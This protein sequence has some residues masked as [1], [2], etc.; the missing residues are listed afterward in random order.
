MTGDGNEIGV[1]RDAHQ[2][3]PWYG[4]PSTWMGTSRVRA[5]VLGSLVVFLAVCLVVVSLTAY[6]KYRSVWDSI[7]RVQVS[8]LGNR[9]PQFNNAMNVLLI[10]S[11]SRSGANSGFGTGITGQR[12]DTIIVLHLAPGG[13]SAVV[14]SI[15]R[16]SVVPI[17]SCPREAG[18]PGQAAQP[19]QVEQINATFAYGGPGCLWKTLEQTTHLRIDHFIE[20]NFTG[21]EHVIN[22]IGGV[23]I[24]LPFA[25]NDPLSRL[26]LTAGR[27][28][29]GGTE[30]LAFWRARYIGEGSDLQRIE[31]DQYL[32]AAVLQGAEHSDLLGSP[33]RLLAVITDVA[34]S[35]TTDTG[36]SPS[37]LFHVV[38]SLR[39][40][41]PGAVQF[42]E[43][44]TVA[45]PANPDWV[46][47]PSSDSQL[48]R[49]IAH[50]R[51]V[52]RTASTAAPSRRAGP[53]ALT[54]YLPRHRAP[55][56]PAPSGSPN[57]TKRYGGITGNA[58]IC[59]N[60]QAFSGPLGGS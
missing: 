54:V 10:G 19:G 59:G 26:H 46:E 45:Y 44:P 55:A 14:L 21:F 1:S 36:L 57:L 15:P 16:D 8:G 7:R 53:P 40:M 28:H 33:T 43:L 17:L 5:R 3:R 50:D 4:I 12:S 58:N 2:A 9:P 56:A 11:D 31:R 42:V 13:R 52:P 51:M 22:D 18:T 60:S 24:C 6:L 20:L 37:T 34:K 35:M 23:N 29:V 39:Q 25:I 38:E 27:H 41:R 47:W 49:A 30:A 32:M 48:F